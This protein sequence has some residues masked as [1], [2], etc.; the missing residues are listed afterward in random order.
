MHCTKCA[1]CGFRND[2]LFYIDNF[3]VKK[4]DMRPENAPKK[5]GIRNISDIYLGPTPIPTQFQA[6]F[7]G[8]ALFAA[9]KH[10][11]LPATIARGLSEALDP[12]LFRE[13]H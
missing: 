2:R 3:G 13:Y 1:I 11:P 4:C 5:G 7:Q 10:V 12:L 9:I 6:Q 8:Q